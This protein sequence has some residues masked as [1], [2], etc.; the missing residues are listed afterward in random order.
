MMPGSGFSVHSL[1]WRHV[2]STISSTFASRTFLRAIATASASMSPPYILQA[3][4]FSALSSLY[5]SSKSS[6]SKSGH[7]S[8]ANCCRNIPG[9]MLAAIR[10][11]SIRKVPEPHI[12]S[13]KLLSPLHPVFIMIPAARTSLMGA[14]VCSTL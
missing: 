5:I 12:G 6:L 3:N 14:A 11:A 9:F 13:T 10:A 8:N 7:F 1:I 2:I 4:S